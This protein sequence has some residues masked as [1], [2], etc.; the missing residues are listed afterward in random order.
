MYSPGLLFAITLL[1]IKQ[2]IIKSVHSFI[3]LKDKCTVYCNS[4]R[5]LNLDSISALVYERT[6]LAFS[7]EAK[8]EF[9]H[10]WIEFLVGLWVFR[11]SFSVMILSGTSARSFGGAPAAD[12]WLAH[13]CC[14]NHHENN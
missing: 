12:L 2:R 11:R 5:L 13:A 9:R 1:A 4:Q 6:I 10:D 14:P 3:L 7:N 8:R